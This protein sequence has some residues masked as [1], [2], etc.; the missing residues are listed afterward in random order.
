MGYVNNTRQY[1]AHD[2]DVY[3]INHIVRAQY[4]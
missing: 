3:G 4:S 2:I 1:I